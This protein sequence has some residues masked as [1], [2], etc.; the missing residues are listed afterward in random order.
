[1]PDLSL[2][3]PPPASKRSADSAA[4][5]HRQAPARSS[6]SYPS[7]THTQQQLP[8]A[9]SAA[10]AALPQSAPRALRPAPCAPAAPACPLT[11]CAQAAPAAPAPAAP[12]PAPA[13]PDV[14]GRRMKP[15]APDVCGHPC[16]GRSGRAGGRISF[17]DVVRGLGAAR[18]CQSA[19]PTLLGRLPQRNRRSD[20]S[21]LSHRR[22][23][24][25]RPGGVPPRLMQAGA[26]GWGSDPP[27]AQ[28]VG[29]GWVYSSAPQIG[30]SSWPLWP[31]RSS[32]H[33]GGDGSQDA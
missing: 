18:R 30:P 15:G 23:V 22:Q 11:P 16:P 17:A 28:Q 26:S 5:S 13:A 29:S 31:A 14:C 20:D 12:A 21:R 6:S 9:R 27:P 1:M 4:E 25:T 2:L 24:Q 33:H 10:A 7:R 3:S 19:T 32:S 8:P